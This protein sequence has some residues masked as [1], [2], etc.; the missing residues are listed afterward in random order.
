MSIFDSIL[1]KR[2]NRSL[3]NLSHEFKMTGNFGYL[4]PILSQEV[5]PGDTWKVSSEV[6]CRFAPLI[7]PIMHRINLKINYFFVPY[8]LIWDEFEDFITGGEDGT[9]FPVRPTIK[10]NIGPRSTQNKYIKAGSLADYLG[11]PTFEE[12]E[13]SQLSISRDFDFDALPFR[14]YALIW[15]EYYRNQ[16]LQDKLAFSKDSGPGFSVQI[17]DLQRRCW[18]KDYFTSALPDVQRG[19]AVAI[20]VEG[21]IAIAGMVGQNVGVDVNRIQPA[22]ASIPAFQTTMHSSGGNRTFVSSKG[23]GDGFADGTDVKLHGSLASTSIASVLAARLTEITSTIND[24]RDNTHL[25]RFLEKNMRGGSRYTEQIYAHYGVRS[26]D[27][28]LQ[29][30]EYLG[31]YSA[32]VVVSEVL[33]NSG[34]VPGQTPQATMAGHGMVADRSHYCKRFFEEHGIIMG[35][36][37]VLPRTTYQQGLPRQYQRT[38]RYDV[39]WPEF[40]N[41]G[42]Q[43]VRNNELFYNL[44]S[45]DGDS[46]PFGYQQ[47]Y[48]EYKYIPS[49]VHGEFKT[50]LDFW[51]LGRIFDTPPALN[52]DFVSSNDVRNDVFAVDDEEAAHK[53]WIEVYN[54]IRAVRP[55]PRHANPVI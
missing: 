31:G 1:V 19:P 21:S 16:N 20:P 55:M 43:D 46:T 18:E 33:Q 4:Y 5:L 29:R 23:E 28:R 37:S 32:P 30:P 13:L 47:R 54:N 41:L 11:F 48:C 36:L 44:Q 15:N 39:Y 27:A 12:E 9:L 3:F 24:L 6:L 34:S 7:T 2:P 14:A 45:P 38:T 26:S 49:T 25:Q 10:I 35:L 40:A 42:E 17:L 52:S 22:N 8:R 50:S 53:L 51:H